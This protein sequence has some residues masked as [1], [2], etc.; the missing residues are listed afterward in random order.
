MTKDRGRGV[1]ATRDIHKG[2]LIVVEKAVAEV[3][4]DANQL[5]GLGFSSAQFVN[6]GGHQ[7][8]V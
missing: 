1:F 5:G 2:G 3:I 8:L 6:D 7:Q 4:R